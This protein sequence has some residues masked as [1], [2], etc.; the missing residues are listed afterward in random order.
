MN[1][2]PCPDH[3]TNTPYGSGKYKTLLSAR[4]WAGLPRN[5]RTRQGERVSTGTESRLPGEVSRS[6]EP[7]VAFC[8]INKGKTKI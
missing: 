4:G 1:S 8:E 6:Q 5:Q 7:Q 3:S 2:L